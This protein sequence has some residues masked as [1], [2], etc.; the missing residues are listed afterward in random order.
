[1]EGDDEVRRGD[2]LEEGG[3][4]F[5]KRPRPTNENPNFVKEYFAASRLHFIGSFRARYE[6]MMAA[7][8][9]KLNVEPSVLLSMPPP[10][11]KPR[12]QRERIIV[13]I[14]M[15]CFFASVAVSL[16]P[17]LAGKPIAVCHSR[18]SPDGSTTIGSG[19]V[20]SCSYEARAY[21]VRRGMFFKQAKELCP[22][23]IGVPYHFP[24]YEKVSINA[25]SRFHAYKG[26]VV[27]AVS[28]DEAYIDLTAVVS[29]G[30]ESS[31]NGPEQLVEDLRA[32]I[33][34]DTGCH[35]SAGVGPSRLVARLATK[36]A[37][38][39]GQL[40]I[41]QE[42][43][44]EFVSSMSVK[45][46]P[47]VGWRTSARLKEQGIETCSQLRN[48][49]L[50]TLQD[51]FGEKQ[52]KSFYDTVRGVDDKPVE[53]LKP[54]KSIGAEASWG[55]R[56]T[57]SDEDKG[58]AV[59]FISD[60]AG[61][62]A[63]R[64]VAAGGMGS[65]LVYK[66]YR[67]REG[68]GE[69]PKFLGHGSCEIFTRSAKLPAGLD[70][71]TLSASMRNVCLKLHKELKIP[72]GLLRG[73]G[74]QLTELTFSNL[75]F[76]TKRN[77]IPSD[78]IRIDS[79]LTRGSGSKGALAQG[80]PLETRRKRTQ[81]QESQIVEP[82]SKRLCQEDAGL[83]EES[84]SL[85]K[86]SAGKPVLSQEAIGAPKTS[87]TARS[88]ELQT[89]DGVSEAHAERRSC[90]DNSSQGV[91][92]TQVALPNSQGLGKA[93]PTV[94]DKAP[95]CTESRA[96]LPDEWDESVYDALPTQIREELLHDHLRRIAE[97][98]VAE[99]SPSPEHTSE[100]TH[101]KSDVQERE[102][103]EDSVQQD[104]CKV[105]KN[106]RE[107]ATITQFADVAKL[108]AHGYSIVNAS[109]FASKR[110]N[111]C[112][113]LFADLKEGAKGSKKLVCFAGGASEPA[114]APPG[115]VSDTGSSDSV[116]EDEAEWEIP[117]PPDLSSDSEGSIGI[118]AA[119]ERAGATQRRIFE[120]E[121]VVQYAGNLK[122][123][124]ASIGHDIRS[125]HV[126]L[127]RGR[128]LELVRLRELARTCAEM[129][130]LRAFASDLPE[131]EWAITFNRLLGD[132]Q[133]VC[134][135]EHGFE[136]ALQEL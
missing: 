34:A 33:F 94:P 36:R 78:N 76:D 86:R 2:R 59:K 19:E 103:A 65:K 55:V 44:S 109:Q 114:E 53:P 119:V 75:G 107:Q 58:K 131:T 20:S 95:P 96:V 92:G 43:A 40:R 13:H 134:N 120:D 16:D 72:D 6:S 126:E 88:N 105:D 54:R 100:E 90:D 39:N 132:V 50:A 31:P 122:S 98:D 3:G 26:A 97:K 130:V 29:S 38:P 8:A 41:L 14:D 15:D 113:E 91:E 63:S 129:R 71:D 24:A 22:E 136:L 47:G 81:E 73:V 32:K 108:K 9:K 116:N 87:P 84:I 51:E 115:S 89:G 112:L 48:L 28:V 102:S 52:G 4:D 35:A 10:E 83:S 128:L 125:A 111:E 80:A 121:G 5:W 82:A 27:E 67:R 49:Q 69:P 77:T 64:V 106:R 99:I 23:L 74:V 30:P 123:W 62:V 45:D 79:F 101:K 135:Q 46:L 93:V 37:K 56:F 60:L 124:M 117:S 66:A 68:A 17:S 12:K 42:N 70:S 18:E 61:E 104:H 133:Q 7:V 118:T 127:L 11:S 110:M 25:Y 21:G 57:D 85:R 1:M